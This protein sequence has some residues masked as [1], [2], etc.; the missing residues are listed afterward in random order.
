MIVQI[1][2]E[3]GD[4][5]VAE[6]VHGHL[7]VVVVTPEVRANILRVT[8]VKGVLEVEVVPTTLVRIKITN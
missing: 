2:V 4:L 8:P 5:V 7:E 3:M 1:M 6:Q